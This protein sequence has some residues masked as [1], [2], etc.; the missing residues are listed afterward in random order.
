MV[1]RII[2][3][4]Q[5]AQR[6]EQSA[7]QVWRN[8]AHPRSRV[9]SSRCRGPGEPLRCITADQVDLGL[10]LVAEITLIDT[11]DLSGCL[12]LSDLVP[13]PERLDLCY[14]EPD[15]RDGQFDR[16]YRCQRPRPF[17]RCSIGQDK[18]LQ[19]VLG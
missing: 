7:N 1:G 9:Y 3:A 14:L 8:A 18:G 15:L 19:N 13:V 2:E 11:V 12:Q 5:I 17:R 4:G 6:S 16:S 10:R